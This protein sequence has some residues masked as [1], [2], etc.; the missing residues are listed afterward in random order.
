MAVIEITN[1]KTLYH[2]NRENITINY[3]IEKSH[4]PNLF[5]HKVVQF[6]LVLFGGHL[7][8]IM[9]YFMLMEKIGR[10]VNS[11]LCLLKMTI[12]I[13]GLFVWEQ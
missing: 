5:K 4:R 9:V 13:G 10:E 12:L 11:I 6:L 1:R 2:N 3:I 7:N 8:D